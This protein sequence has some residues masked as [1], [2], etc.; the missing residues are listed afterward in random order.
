MR[1]RTPSLPTAL[2]VAPA[3]HVRAV[4]PCLTALTLG[5][6]ALGLSVAALALSIAALPTPLALAAFG[7]PVLVSGSPSI[8]A[9]YAYNPAISA[10][11]AISADGHRGYVAF[12]GSVDSVPGVYRKDLQSEAVELVAGGDASAPSISADGRYVSFTTSHNPISGEVECSAVWVR[13]MEPG[14]GE[15]TYELA[16]ALDGSSESLTYA[17]SGKPGCPGGG[18]AAASRVALSADGREVAFTA[19]GE[20]DL[21]TGG[22]SGGAPPATTTP[23]DQVIVRNLTTN[24]TTLV[25]ATLASQQPGAIPE[26]VPGGAALAGNEIDKEGQLAGMGIQ[27]D[28][29]E[30]PVSAATAAISADGST[31]AWMG[32]NIPEQA[33]AAAEDEAHAIGNRYADDYDEPLWRRIADESGAPTRRILGGDDP[34]SPTGEGPL[35]LHWNGTSSFIEPADV[36][37]ELGAYIEVKDFDQ[38]ARYEDATGTPTFESITPQLSANGETV[39]LLS[40]APP[41]GAEPTYGAGTK[42]PNV[43]PSANAY[44]VNMASGLTRSQAVTPL[45]EWGANDFG[46]D[47]ANTAP[48]NGIAL[49]AD[50][51]RVAFTT[52][53]TVFPLT[54]PVLITPQVTNISDSQLYEVDL[55]SNTL[56]LVSEGYEGSPAEGNVYSPSFSGDGNTLAFASAAHN[57]VYGTVNSGDSD[58]FATAAVTTP[59]APGVQSIAPLPPE[60]PPVPQWLIGATLR[61]GPAGS[62]LLD[63]SV[64]GAGKLYAAASAA[65][66]VDAS[67][68]PSTAHG[69]AHKSTAPRQR[70][71]PRDATRASARTHTTIV[72]RTL[73]NAAA[74]PLAA[75]LVQLRLLP[76]SRYRSLEQSRGGLY[77]TIKITFTAHGHKGLMQTLQGSFQ[78]AVPAHS[79]RRP[80]TRTRAANRSSH[81]DTRGARTGRGA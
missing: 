74:N 53:R 1:R 76:A 44:V 43:P 73:I 75:G 31:V 79:S 5:V 17:G 33:P 27:E 63:V 69:R 70:A 35:N 37:P 39:A 30:H 66:P 61:R 68:K 28:G 13:D 38:A 48:I 24:T 22:S 45:T 58:V 3:L 52:R 21:G 72:T 23:P 47:V 15:P 81:A 41:Y 64:P 50:G 49:S 10:D 7:Q 29:A 67:A 8:Q 25:S 55:R 65:V 9:D 34:A 77:A 16:S 4:A 46:P 60:P 36:G 51:T 42:E 20:S 80:D 57:L 18:S 40:T 6:T 26:P 56:A 14:A 2:G 11:A 54:P 62:L 71:T 59:E 32:V 78:L 19:I 12:T